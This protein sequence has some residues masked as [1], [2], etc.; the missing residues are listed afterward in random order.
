MNNKYG[1]DDSNR[2]CFK[3]KIFVAKVTSGNKS[4]PRYFGNKYFK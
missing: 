3:G 1:D 4:K 2:C